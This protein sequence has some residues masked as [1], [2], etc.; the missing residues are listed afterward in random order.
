M[1]LAEISVPLPLYR[2]ESDVTYHTERKPTVF[3]R[4]V[5]R[6]CDPGLHLPDKQNLSLQGVFRDQLGAGD[7][8]ELLEGC[9]SELSALGAL[10][11]SY[12]QDR[13]EMPLTELELTPDG[14]QFLRSDSLPVR[15]RTVKVWHHYDPIS[16]EIKPSQN[17]G[18][19]LSQIDFSRI[20]LAD[21]A[22]RPQNPMPQ[23]ERAIAQET[24]VWKNPATVIDLIVPMVQP[25]GSGERRL[26]LSCSEDGAL[27]ASAPRDAALQCWLE[28]AQPELV[29]EILLADALTSEP[30]SL[31]PS[32]DSAV[33]RDARTARPIAATKGGATRARF[34]IVAQGVAAADATTPTIVLSSEVNSPALVANGKQPTAFTLLVPAP[35][36][37]MTGFRS[38]SLPQND[39]AS[40]QV[41]VAGNFRLYWAG[42]PR[43]CGL[44]V[45]LNDQ[46]ATALWA[47]LRQELEISCESS[48]DP[49]IALMPVAWRSSDELGEIVWPWLAMRA[50]RPLDDLMALVEPATQA[51]GLWRP[52]RKDW[53]SAWEECL[54][55]VIDESLR[56]TP[57]QL[58]PEEVV[59]LLAQ[60]Y[61]VLSSD[62]AAP[63]QGA[64]LH[65]AA[66]IR[67]MESMAKLRSALPS[68]T[69]I[70]EELL[71]SEL[72]Q[73][74]LEN[75]LQRKELKLYGPHAMQQPI[76]VI[77][78][79]IQD[80][81]RSI[82]DQAL[83]AAGNGQM[84]V[85]TLTPGAL[86]AVRAWRKAAEHF[87]ALNTPS[88]LWD[89]LS[90]TVESWNLL[91]QDKLAPVENGRRIVVFDTS[92]LMESSELFQD[93]R[94]DDIPVV[95][96]RVLSELD[97]LKS[98]EDGDRAAKAREA[99]RQL[100]ANSSRIRHETEYAALL[101]VE[102]GVK[103]PDHAILST[104]L[105]FRLND[106]L[107]VSNDINLR[108]K[109]NSLGLKTQDSNIY[110]PSR[111]VPANSPKMHPRKQN[112]S[113]RR[114]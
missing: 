51:I 101:P 57:N 67:T 99:I 114:K 70:P 61:Q 21:Q 103:Q 68:T 112:N 93:L 62:K 5:L 108:N 80:I 4:M 48:D 60:I 36:G 81:Y 11:K 109:A 37:I 97:G 30:D 17:D 8:R 84:D 9:V 50:E 10:P 46:V 23:V 100:D 54:A 20:R 105:F 83:K 64:L 55:K 49:R 98:S 79:A 111:L 94:S 34:C 63:L 22:L 31:L 71:S 47:T 85:R 96:H 104:A 92:A 74:W 107:F 75:A 7:V 35:A 69:E 52:D 33:L 82:G 77:E 24:H 113:K 58:E 106:V 43:S 72:R 45:T 91:A 18:A 89:A 102:W 29:W 78:K 66:P 39:G 42:Q 65:H 73:V 12:A 25:V 32:V 13:L 110:A 3:E 44:A 15:S 56:H 16:D 26:E 38:L 40:I 28:Q 27:S 41:E 6:L 90:K 59:S 19:R 76:Q 87:Q 53:K 86:N 1:K 88:S 95:P 14:L 2:I